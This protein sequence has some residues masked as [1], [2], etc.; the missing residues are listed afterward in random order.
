MTRRPAPSGGSGFPSAPVVVRAP[1]TS[2][3]LGPGFDTFGLALGLHD[4]VEVTATAR[5]LEVDV[6]GEGVGDLPRN[7]DH[8]VVR[9]LRATLDSLGLPQPG[10]RLRCRNSVPQGR[11]LGSSAAA[12]VAGIRLA[13]ALAPDSA[14]APGRDL[15]LAVALEGHP[16]NVAACMLGGL[17]I[18][19]TESFAAS[20]TRPLPADPTPPPGEAD[21]GSSAVKAVRLEVHPHVRP[22]LF[23]PSAPVPTHVARRLLPDVVRH[24]DARQNAAVAGLLVA[25]LTT[26]PEHLLAATEDRLHQDYRRPAMPETMHL[27]DRLRAAGV[28]AVVSGAGPAV[29][30]LVTDEPPVDAAPWT[31]A[32]WSVAELRVDPDGAVGIRPGRRRLDQVHDS[33]DR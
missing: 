18:A 12:I 6:G 15:Q 28:A 10:L 16:D 24:V 8:L 29:L 4:W 33:S 32:G 11:G 3:N 26:Y 19:W 20:T 14:L 30:A 7:E 31:P 2:A 9:A 5:G 23:V 22:V 17:T 21:P 1:A 25:A 13:E 27:V